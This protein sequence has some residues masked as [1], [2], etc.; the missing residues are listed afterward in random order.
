MFFFFSKYIQD[1]DATCLCTQE[2]EITA[3]QNGNDIALNGNVNIEKDEN[4]IEDTVTEEAIIDHSEMPIL[5]DIQLL[6]GSDEKDNFNEVVNDLV[7]IN[8]LLSIFEIS[9]FN[10]VAGCSFFGK[11]RVQHGQQLHGHQAEIIPRAICA[12]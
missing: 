12:N 11:H 8:T 3:C 6:N 7:C 9:V 1:E 10:S 4:N 2:A 5:N